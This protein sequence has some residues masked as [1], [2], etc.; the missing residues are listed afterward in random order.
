[1]DFNLSFVKFPDHIDFVKLVT[2]AQRQADQDGVAVAV[3]WRGYTTNITPNQPEFGT[4][5]LKQELYN[6]LKGVEKLS[7]AENSVTHI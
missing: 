2:D 3:E 1:M 4:N 5:T 7:E 6:A